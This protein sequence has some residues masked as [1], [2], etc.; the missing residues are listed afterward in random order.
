MDIL[1]NLTELLLVC[2]RDVK[3]PVNP[4]KRSR[5]VHLKQ[6]SKLEILNFIYINAVGD[7]V[8][9]LYFKMKST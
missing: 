8:I 6:R 7:W 3:I 1:V 4:M 5:T 9:K 2:P